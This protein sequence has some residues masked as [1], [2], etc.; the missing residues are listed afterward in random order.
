M[1]REK[2]KEKEKMKKRAIISKRMIVRI[3]I[4]ALILF[5]LSW[6]TTIVKTSI[7]DY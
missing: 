3:I 1:V 4:P 7:N 5:S 6:N 2:D